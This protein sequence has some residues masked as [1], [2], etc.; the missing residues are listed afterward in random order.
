[1]LTL[2]KVKTVNELKE[3]YLV[4]S[5]L[6]RNIDWIQLHSYGIGEWLSRYSNITQSNGIQKMKR[7]LT[8]V[9]REVGSDVEEPY[10]ES[11]LDYADYRT[12]ADIPHYRTID[13]ILDD[14]I[15]YI[16]FK[17]NHSTIKN[18]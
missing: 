12:S 3:D 1:M 7:K 18:D 2:L 14:S 4:H 8:N 10:A 13:N 11:L 5:D 6:H 15:S 16:G 17:L 9:K